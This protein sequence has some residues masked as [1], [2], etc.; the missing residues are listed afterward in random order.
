[1][2]PLDKI[3]DHH[4]YLL[5]FFINFIFSCNLC[6][7]APIPATTHRLPKLLHTIN[8]INDAFQISVFVQTELDDLRSSSRELN[9]RDFRLCWAN[10]K[11]RRDLFQELSNFRKLP[12]RVDT[13]RSVHKEGQV[14]WLGTICNKNFTGTLSRADLRKRPTKL[15]LPG[16]V[17]EISAFSFSTAPFCSEDVPD[18]ASAFPDCP[19]LVPDWPLAVPDWPLVVPD[20]PLAVPDW[21]LAVP[22]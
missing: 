17:L 14:D 13:S 2:L 8:A 22:D 5:D 21:P 20:W 3:K 1:V 4:E 18:C 15:Y 9:E 11:F 10:L 6:P 19:P 7:T 12:I 16:G